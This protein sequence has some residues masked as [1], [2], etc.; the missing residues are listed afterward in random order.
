MVTELTNGKFNEFIKEGTVL[1]DFYADWC[2]PCVMMGPI[3]EDVAEKFV[4]KLKV[5]KV[6]VEDGHEIAQKFNVSSIPNFVLFKEGK[7]AANF[8]GAMSEEDFSEK[9]K[10]FL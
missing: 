8:V 1:I 6:N 5:G 3:V 4:K 7:V 10:K 2:M 9:L